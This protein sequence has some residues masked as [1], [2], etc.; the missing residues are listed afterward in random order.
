VHSNQKLELTLGKP[1]HP[2]P[3][4]YDPRPDLWFDHKLWERLF[5]YIDQLGSSQRVFF[6]VLHGFRCGG[7]RILPRNRRLH[8]TYDN[9]LMGRSGCGRW[10]VE[11]LRSWLLPYGV[12][13]TTAFHWLERRGG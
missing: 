13:I 11:E 3:I 9:L 7:A 1:S 4:T 2:S 8:L 12:G 5:G 10:E 6:G